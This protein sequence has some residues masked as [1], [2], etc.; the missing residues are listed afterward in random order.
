MSRVPRQYPSTAFYPNH[1]FF[2]LEMEQYRFMLHETRIVS[3]ITDA[4]LFS[5]PKITNLYNRCIYSL[6]LH[7]FQP[8]IIRDYFGKYCLTIDNRC[9]SEM[10]TVVDE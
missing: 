5:E 1:N 7:E 9:L 8:D 10:E 6:L 4:I 3:Q 2:I